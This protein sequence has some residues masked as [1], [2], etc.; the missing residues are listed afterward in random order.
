MLIINIFKGVYKHII[1]YNFDYF[2]KIIFEIFINN[3][4]FCDILIV[5]V[6]F[7]SLLLKI[8]IEIFLVV[9]KPE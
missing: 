8:L 9:S 2:S 5:Y 3:S 6:G 7:L 1:F 4:I